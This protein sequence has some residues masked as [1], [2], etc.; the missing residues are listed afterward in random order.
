MTNFLEDIV[1]RAVEEG[2]VECLFVTGLTSRGVDLLERMVD[3]YGDIQ[4]ASLVM[5]FVVPR[6]FKDRRV[7]EWIER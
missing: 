7:E 5:S 2:D 6:R 1:S 3:R 4:T